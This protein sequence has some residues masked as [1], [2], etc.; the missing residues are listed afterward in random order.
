MI[1]TIEV[2]TTLTISKGEYS[3]Y[4]TY[5]VFTCVANCDVD[6]NLKEYLSERK[7]ETRAYGFNHEGFKNHLVEKGYFERIESKELYLGDYGE[8]DRIRIHDGDW[9]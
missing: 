8:T 4:M 9:N 6:E 3:E 7:I 5:G 2:G 1:G